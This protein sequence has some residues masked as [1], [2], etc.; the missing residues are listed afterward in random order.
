MCAMSIALGFGCRARVDPAAASAQKSER[1]RHS[2]RRL[3]EESQLLA[4][5]V[6]MREWERAERSLRNLRIELASVE[7]QEKREYLEMEKD[8]SA[9]DHE[10]R[11]HRESTVIGA[12]D[13]FSSD[14]EKTNDV[15]SREVTQ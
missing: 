5:F 11:L 14:L 15:R 8:L 3:Q 2:H 13:R 7:A 9:L 10:L 6:R 12:L 4:G 1:S